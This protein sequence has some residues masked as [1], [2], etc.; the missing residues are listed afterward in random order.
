MNYAKIEF[1]YKQQKPD[2]SL[3][4]SLAGQLRSEEKPLS[5]GPAPV[6]VHGVRSALRDGRAHKLKL[7]APMSPSAGPVPAERRFR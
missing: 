3:G 5:G 4:G 1:S 7:P 2:G 6:T